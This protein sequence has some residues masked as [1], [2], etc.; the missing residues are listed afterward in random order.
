[1]LRSRGSVE[2][3]EDGQEILRKGHT[4]SIPGQRRGDSLE[5][6]CSRVMSREENE[7]WTQSETVHED[8][9]VI[10]NLVI[11]ERAQNS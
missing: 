8:T 7:T 10:A 11:K 3:K 4:Y 5:A 9:I 2:Y 6:G 1:M